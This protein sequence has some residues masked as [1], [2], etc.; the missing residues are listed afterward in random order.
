MAI[1]STT[2]K[3]GQKPTKAEQEHIQLEIELAKCRPYT[4]DPD[5]PLLTE[6]QFAQFK[7]A[8]GMTW[9]ERAILMEEAY[10]NGTLE[11]PRSEDFFEGKPIK[12]IGKTLT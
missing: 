11:R 3:V 7:P 5:C 6:E 8:N 2:I 9:E 4:Y 12:E 1:I 10:R